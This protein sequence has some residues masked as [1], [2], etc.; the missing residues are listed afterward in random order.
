VIARL[1]WHELRQQLGGRVFWIVFAVSV[2][3]VAGAMAIDELRVGLSDE[4]ARTGA[5]AIV[6]MNLV[7]TLF[8]LFTAAAFVGEAAVRDEVR[9]FAELVRATSVTARSYALGRF[10]GA[11]GAV[12]L[13]FLSVPAAMAAA[14]ALLGLGPGRP[15]AHLFA[16]SVLALPNLALASALFF[17]LASVTR[18]MTG[19][20]LGA[21]GLLTLYGLASHGGSP[22]LSLVE[23][24]GLAAVAEA[25]QGWSPAQRDA[26]LPALG[27]ALL[28][29]R[30]LWLV[31]SATLVG[32]GTWLAAPRVRRSGLRRSPLMGVVDGANPSPAAALPV[33]EQ[34]APSSLRALSGW[35]VVATQIRVRTMFEARRVIVTP[36]FAVLL[37][38][39][40][41][42]AVAA[43]ARVTGTPATVAALA[44]SF[45]LVPVVVALFF[46]GE[47]FWAE[48]EH[49]V[50]PFI[51]ATP[52]G[53]AVLVLP[54]LLALALVLLLLAAASAGAGAVAELARG[55][56]PVLAAYLAWY[57]FPKAYEWL[58]LGV[59]ALFLQ[60][61]ASS[62]LAGWGY[63]VFYLI[64]S[65]ALNRLG[66]HDPHYRYGGYPGAPLPP[67]LSGAQGVIW[68]QLGWGTVA[69]AM[70][71]LACRQG[72]RTGRR[73][74]N[75]W[76]APANDSV[77]PAERPQLPRTTR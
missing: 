11:F 15:G 36:V 38:M 46:A 3:M 74:G 47:L 45:Q 20:L 59:L 13:C 56:S 1:A 63:M 26:M 4:G 2:L 76:C 34:P 44:R 61:L 62:K 22:G 18:S 6:R 53:R 60:S 51:A 65:L 17:A 68:Y 25:T 32:L 29:N 55:H 52:A 40:L 77:E 64:G 72:F 28:A 33:G 12:L 24:F 73:R 14:G 57:V 30:M 9:G 58:L 39:G 21:A 10:L 31:V 71:V 7:W 49:N 35:S 16:F 48:R 27:G 19:C 42:A 66:W 43:A 54:K 8:F 75:R 69:A 37:L 23:P 5:A 41:A 50:A 67:A 70:V